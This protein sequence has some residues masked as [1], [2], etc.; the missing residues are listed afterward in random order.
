MGVLFRLQEI[1]IGHTI[2]FLS[3]ILS[4]CLSIGFA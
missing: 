4:L 1:N 2:L 3:V